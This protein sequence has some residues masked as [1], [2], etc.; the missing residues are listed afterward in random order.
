MK[1]GFDYTGL[2]STFVCHDGNGK[3][4]MARRGPKARD[5]YGK[6]EFGGGGIDFGESPEDTARRELAEEYGCT[7]IYAIRPLDPF[8]L[9][10]E[11]ESLKTHWIGFP[12]L[13]QVD[14]ADIRINEV[15]CIDKIGWFEIDHLPEP[16]LSG[17][18]FIVE[19][20]RRYQQQSI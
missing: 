4:L 20:Y 6:W 5:E 14:P 17:V 19:S 2:F 9:V 8:S 13:I 7:K 16:C 11:Q 10:R 18:K 15:G 3:F 12:F 1:P